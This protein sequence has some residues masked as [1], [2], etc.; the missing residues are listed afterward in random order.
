[1]DCML[2][3]E[4]KDVN[5]IKYYRQIIVS[6]GNLVK[7]FST[8]SRNAYLLAAFAIVCTGSGAVVNKFIQPI[9]S[10]GRV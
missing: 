2:K 4:N 6:G 3:N 8:I 7:R 5:K 10:S 9:V 1:M